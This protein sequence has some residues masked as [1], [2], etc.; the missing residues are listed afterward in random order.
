M[1]ID[2]SN[3]MTC[4]QV[5][6]ELGC[7]RR[8]VYRAAKRAEDDGCVVR[9]EILGRSVFL[10]SGL[11]ALKAH[12]YPYYSDAH[13]LMVRE[14]GRRGGSAKGKRDDQSDK[15]DKVDADSTSRRTRRKPS[16]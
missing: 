4:Q 13:Q 2:T 5:M 3:Y 1:K 15:A 7:P 16:P 11:P 14:W 6:A 8:A 12:Y 10:R 9:A